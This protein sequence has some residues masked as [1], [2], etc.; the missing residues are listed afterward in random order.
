MHDDHPSSGRRNIGCPGYA[1]LTLQAH[2]PDPTFEMLYVWFAQSLQAVALDHS[3]DAEEMRANVWSL[4]IE[5]G[6]DGV[7]HEFD[8]PWHGGIIPSMQC[9]AS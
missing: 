2:L 3:H 9:E 5:Q 8:L 1:V 6:L 4:P 7:V